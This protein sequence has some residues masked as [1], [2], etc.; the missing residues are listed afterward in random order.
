MHVLNSH[1]SM[2]RTQ[3]STIALMIRK[4]CSSYSCF[5]PNWRFW[6][7]WATCEIWHSI[8]SAA[9]GSWVQWLLY[10]T[11]FSWSR[12]SLQQLL[13]NLV[14][15]VFSYLSFAFSCSWCGV[16]RTQGYSVQLTQW[17]TW[18]VNPVGT[19]VSLYSCSFL[20]SKPA[21]SSYR[22]I[23]IWELRLF[24]DLYGIDLR[25]IQ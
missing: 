5:L 19:A 15:T 11:H 16:Y 23:R 12:C 8:L 20:H 10:A 24:I 7:C 4:I 9:A 1:L 2:P 17:R 25:S 6:R 22:I 13:L 18:I 14:R 3:L 21:G